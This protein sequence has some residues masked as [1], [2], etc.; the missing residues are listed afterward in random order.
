MLS[1][2]GAPP[3]RPRPALTIRGAA[4]LLAASLAAPACAAR[5]PEPLAVPSPVSARDTRVRALQRDIAAL[6]ASPTLARGTTGIAVVSL[7]RGDTLFR[8]QADRLLMPASTMKLLTLAAAAERLGWDHAFSTTLAST[9]SIQDGVLRGDLVVRGT[10]DP[11]IN[12]RD[13]AAAR[14]FDDWAG[15]L[16]AQGLQRID[17][18]LVGDDGAFEEEPYGTGWAWDNLA[19]GY[20][21][22]VGALQVNEDLVELVIT[23]AAQEGTAARVEQVP[24][25]SGLLVEATVA[26]GVPGSATDIHARRSPGTMHAVVTGSVPAGGSPVRR[27]LSVDNPTIYF[28]REFA[29][30]LARNGISVA[31]ALVDADDLRP[32]VPRGDVILIEH[33]SP[34]LR[35]IARVLLKASQNLYAETV[36]RAIDTQGVSAPGDAKT[37][38]IESLGRMG[39]PAD[40]VVIADGSGLSRY[41]YATADALVAVL[42]R[43]HADPSHRDPWMAALPVAGVEGTLQRRF[44][45]TRAEGRV[46]AKTGTISNVRALAGYVPTDGAETLAFAILVNNVTAPAKDIDVVTDAIVERLTTLTRR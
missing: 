2:D 36:Y 32:N 30:A 24:N 9:S 13:G 5:Q 23:P 3:P 38:M 29:A 31:G 39:V 37:A 19:Y 34:P 12:T 43:M 26:T 6:L 4:W 8:H 22:P 42:R 11:T 18:R 17:G 45:G 10:G 21:A 27:T 28:L 46:R 14:V 25:E 20:A 41:N 33:R 40:S 7:D 35:D 16:R 44:K 1:S 15:R